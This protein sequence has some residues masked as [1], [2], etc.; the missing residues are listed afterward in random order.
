MK[1]SVHNIYKWK[2]ELDKKLLKL[3]IKNFSSTQSNSEW[4]AIYTGYKTEDVI[5]DFVSA[6]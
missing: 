1:L 4:L 3:G 6:F 5:R 2:K